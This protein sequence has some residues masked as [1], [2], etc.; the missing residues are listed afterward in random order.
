MSWGDAV[1]AVSLVILAGWLHARWYLL[2][3]EPTPPK[4]SALASSLRA[5]REAGL[6]FHGARL[7]PGYFR[8]ERWLG[9]EDAGWLVEREGLPG[10]GWRV[11][12]ENEVRDALAMS[13]ADKGGEEGGHR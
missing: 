8:Y 3:R 7:L 6:A 10:R 13:V 2:P 4:P 11:D 5:E 9:P 1:L 12:R